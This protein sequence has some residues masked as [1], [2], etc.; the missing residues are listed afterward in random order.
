MTF[1]SPARNRTVTPEP[2]SLF[3][4][5]PIPV[6]RILLEVEILD[7]PELPDRFL[8]LPVDRPLDHLAREVELAQYLGIDG[9]LAV[10]AIAPL[11]SRSA[12]KR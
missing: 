12:V 4:V 5:D 10:V 11:L 8:V 6:L 2:P 3:L 7:G 9:F 1:C